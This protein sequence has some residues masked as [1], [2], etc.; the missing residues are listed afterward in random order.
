MFDAF[1]SYNSGFILM[2]SM[3][4]LSGVM[5]YPVPYIQTFLETKVAS[6]QQCW[7]LI[8][9]SGE[10][11]RRDGTVGGTSQELDQVTTQQSSQQTKGCLL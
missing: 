8:V 5:L 6:P 3:I 7:Y 11:A 4:T 1:G 10:T 9:G 2:G